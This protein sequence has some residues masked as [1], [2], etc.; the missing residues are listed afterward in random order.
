MWTAESGDV[1]VFGGDDA[2]DYCNDLHIVKDAT[3]S[4]SYRWLKVTST[5]DVEKIK[6]IISLLGI[7]NETY[8][9]KM[10]VY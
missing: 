10:S 4:H 9:L 7:K 8:P 6:I 3:R 1:I 5:G 2:N